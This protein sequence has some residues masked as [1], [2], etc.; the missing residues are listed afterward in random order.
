MEQDSL[1]ELTAEIVAAYVSNNRVGAAD[2]SGLIGIVHTALQTM[3]SGEPAA[4]PQTPAA[5]IKRS[6]TADYV[7]CL[8]DGKRFKSLKRHLKTHGLSPAEYRVKWGLPADYPMV[9]PNYARARSD[10]ARQM[11][12]GQ[13]A[14]RR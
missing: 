12:L 5:P 14:A 1:I 8:E 6:V 13:K 3:T 10:L 11:G 7:V 4:E 9:A 2:I